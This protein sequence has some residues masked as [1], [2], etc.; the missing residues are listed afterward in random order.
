MIR[1]MIQSIS[2]MEAVAFVC[3]VFSQSVACKKMRV[4]MRL[5]ITLSQTSPPSVVFPRQI[6]QRAS[7]SMTVLH[8]QGALT[9]LDPSLPGETFQ[10]SAEMS[11]HSLG[12]MLM[13]KDQC[14]SITPSITQ[15]SPHS[16]R[17]V[18]VKKFPAYLS[19]LARA[20]TQ[21]TRLTSTLVSSTS[22]LSR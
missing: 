4:P 21:G 3:L 11:F 18:P 5:S 22:T 16:L 8:Y 13:N 19:S 12:D 20:M 14:H 9:T 6:Q 1:M 7:S 2:M 17:T 10:R 15:S